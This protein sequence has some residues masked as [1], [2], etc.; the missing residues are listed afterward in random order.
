[1][2]IFTVLFATLMAGALAFSS[3]PATASAAKAAS[4]TKPRASVNET[5]PIKLADDE[6]LAHRVVKGSLG[7]WKEA[8][9]VLTRPKG[10]ENIPF[11]GRV[12]V[13]EAGRSTA[14]F[15]LPPPNE[16]VGFFYLIVESIMFRAIDQSGEK[17]VIVLYSSSKIAPM[18]EVRSRVHVFRW[19]GEA[20]EY[21]REVDSTLAG[22]KNA[23][24]VDRRLAK[25]LKRKK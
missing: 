8:T 15:P 7:P 21:A 16:P 20:F 24:E 19:N 1:M 25:L 2:K 6:Q 17:A 22:A 13:R 5:I 3:C 23:R 4:P 11:T 12:V 9:V 18:G 10:D 14:T